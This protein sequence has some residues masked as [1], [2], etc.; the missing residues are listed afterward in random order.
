VLY[1]KNSSKLAA[2]VPLKH[3]KRSGLLIKARKRAPN[4][5]H[6]PTHTKPM[7]AIMMA[8]TNISST[9]VVEPA[10]NSAAAA[11]AMIHAFGFT[12]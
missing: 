4:T 7:L 3:F 1:T 5:S 6:T 2:M 9:G 11:V 10:G 8:T 12:H